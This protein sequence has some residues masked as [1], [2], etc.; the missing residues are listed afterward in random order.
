MHHNCITYFFFASRAKQIKKEIDEKTKKNKIL[1]CAR[2][3]K[4]QHVSLSSYS[5]HSQIANVWC[6]NDKRI[7]YHLVAN[8]DFN[9][10]NIFID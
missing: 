2:R 1:T 3:E 4:N 7:K 5:M 10:L 8:H 9:V 6:G